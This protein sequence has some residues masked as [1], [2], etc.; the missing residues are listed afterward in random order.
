MGSHVGPCATDLARVRHVL[1]L[2]DV[3]DVDVDLPCQRSVALHPQEGL[4]WIQLDQQAVLACDVGWYLQRLL[5]VGEV[6]G[7]LVRQLHRP[8]L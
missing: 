3:V 1:G 6:A 5:V 8:A 7:R 4:G 2:R